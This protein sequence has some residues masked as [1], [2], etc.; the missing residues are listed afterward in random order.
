MEEL[1]SESYVHVTVEH[2]NQP[3]TIVVRDQGETTVQRGDH[4]R[5]G[6]AGPVHLF[7]A[8]DRRLEG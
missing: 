6:F 4:V 1:G 3:T 7:G 8:D 5:I 2:L